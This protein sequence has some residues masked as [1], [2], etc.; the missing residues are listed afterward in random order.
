[1]QLGPYE[2]LG[3]LGR[4]GMGA[5]YKAR[6]ADGRILALKLMLKPGSHAAAQRFD[7]ERRLLEG[8]GEAEGFVPLL[9]AGL[10]PRGPYIVMPFLPGGTLRD[11]IRRGPLA[12]EA[13]AALGEQLAH[14]LGQAHAIGIVHRDLKPENVLFTAPQG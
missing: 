13:A 10:S 3:E 5:V 8:L 1:M 11:V 6:T 9:D 4:G 14:A 12:I 7:R 2:I